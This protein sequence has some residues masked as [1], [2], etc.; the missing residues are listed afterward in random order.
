MRYISH[1]AIVVHDYDEA[2]AFYTEKLGFELAEDTPLSPTKR[3]VRVRP[4]GSECSVLLARADQPEQSAVV[5]RQAGGRVWLFL[6]T[7]DFEAEHQRLLDNGV[8]ITRPAVDEPWGRVLVFADLYGNQWD[9]IQ[10]PVSQ[11]GQ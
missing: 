11:R 8:T 5:G 7:D 2:I 10:P 3:W 9:L 1:F 6:Y 4:P